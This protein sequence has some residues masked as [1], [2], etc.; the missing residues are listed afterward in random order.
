M[1]KHVRGLPIPFEVR[2]TASR[3]FEIEIP[4]DP[5]YAGTFVS[6]LY[7][8]LG[9]AS[10]YQPDAARSGMEV[11]TVWRER[12]DAALVKFDA[13]EPCVYFESRQ[14]A[15]ILE[16]RLSPTG[17]WLPLADLSLCAV[18]GPQ[19]VQGIQGI[20]GIQGPAGADAV[21]YVP[22]ICDLAYHLS[23]YIWSE[24][25]DAFE[26]YYAARLDDGRTVQQ[27][28]YTLMQAIPELAPAYA[29][30]PTIAFA[31]EPATAENRTA[32]RTGL[33]GTARAGLQ[34]QIEGYL[35]VATSRYVGLQNLWLNLY[36]SALYPDQVLV[37]AVTRAHTPDQLWEILCGVCKAPD[38]QCIPTPINP[39]P[40][41]VAIRADGS[42]GG[43]NP[44]S[45]ET[46]NNDAQ[47]LTFDGVWLLSGGFQADA[48]Y[49][50]A[51]GWETYG[52]AAPGGNIATNHA[53]GWVYPAY[54]PT[55]IYVEPCTKG[56]GTTIVLTTELGTAAPADVICL[57]L[58]AVVP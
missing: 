38:E 57:T 34:T 21:T 11:S 4:D 8:Q 19:G 29:G 50:T 3:C 52:S 30:M 42:N 36:S 27:A 41:G 58:G 44:V 53:Y 43:S 9:F 48:F 39:C 37:R 46:G 7:Q 16:Y 45:I 1:K 13:R 22:T 17:S 12:I 23:T 54:S 20:Q 6:L 31:L 32:I 47:L 24:A 55:H 33:E 15:C 56:D 49:T 40:G 51:D 14:V 35:T 5:I 2:P 18:P 25:R 26:L 28:E 10:R